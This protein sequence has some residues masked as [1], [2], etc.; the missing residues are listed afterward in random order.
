MLRGWTRTLDAWALAQRPVWFLE[1]NPMLANVQGFNALLDVAAPLVVRYGYRMWRGD[2]GRH[3]EL[4]ERV[5]AA[6]DAAAGRPAALGAPPPISLQQ[7][8]DEGA[9]CEFN[10][11]LVPAA[12]AAD[13]WAALPPR[14]LLGDPAF[15]ACG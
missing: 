1:L 14:E 12:C 3:G 2:L 4:T 6:A 13:V 15:N 9:P 10:Y 8:I 5:R 7:L 11:M